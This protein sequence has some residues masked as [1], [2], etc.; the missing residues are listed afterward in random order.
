MHSFIPSF[1]KHW[2]ERPLVTDAVLGPG[3][4]T[5]NKIRK[6]SQ[7]GEADVDKMSHIWCSKVIYKRVVAK[8]LRD[9]LGRGH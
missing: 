1:R 7:V 5:M 6:S 2:F 9:I 3:G 4:P 8:G